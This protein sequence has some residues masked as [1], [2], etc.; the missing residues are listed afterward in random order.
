MPFRIISQPIQ[1]AAL[2]HPQAGACATFEGWV[3]NHNEGQAVDSLEYE[4]FAELA[5]KEGERVLAEARERFDLLAVE[6]VHRVGHL[7]IGDL[8]VWVG[9]AAAH[10]GPAFDACRYII[11]EL[12]ARVPIWKREHYAS[13]ETTWINC[14]TRGDFADKTP[15]TAS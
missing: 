8:A 10:R 14:A 5:E 2:L 1:P 4:A 9:V 15:P 7:Q 6:A 13:G 3:R 11:D 12:K